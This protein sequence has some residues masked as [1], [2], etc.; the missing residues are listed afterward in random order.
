MHMRR[1]HHIS[2]N[3][4]AFDTRRLRKLLNDDSS[5]IRSNENRKPVNDG[6]G[7]EDEPRSGMPL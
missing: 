7:N 4:N 6:C 1:H 2:G 5:N 3:R